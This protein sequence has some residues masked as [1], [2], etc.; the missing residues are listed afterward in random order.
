MLDS[1]KPTPTCSQCAQCHLQKV[2]CHCGCERY[3]W[4]NEYIVG[5]TRQ[6]SSADG[7]V[8]RDAFQIIQCVNKVFSHGI[9]TCAKSS[10]EGI[11]NLVLDVYAKVVKSLGY[12]GT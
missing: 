2:A 12:L 9:R 5:N 1:L 6:L 8:K 4:M 7:T 3:Q 11:L 10:I